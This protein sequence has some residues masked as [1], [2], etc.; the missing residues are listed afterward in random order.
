MHAGSIMSITRTLNTNRSEDEKERAIKCKCIKVV[1]SVRVY[2]N[3]SGI[4]PCFAILYMISTPTFSNRMFLFI[5]ILVTFL[6]SIRQSRHLDLY[7]RAHITC[8][9]SMENCAC[10]KAVLSISSIGVLLKMARLILFMRHYKKL[11]CVPPYTKMG[12]VSVLLFMYA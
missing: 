9:Q 10:L 1:P 2:G 12:W 6:A 3:S 7:R 8:M 11:T 4:P 5:Y